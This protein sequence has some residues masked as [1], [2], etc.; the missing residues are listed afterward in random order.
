MHYI[1]SRQNRHY[2][3]WLRTAKAAGHARS[4][5]VLLEG[6]HLCSAWLQHYGAPHAV[7]FDE[8]QM[9]Q[10]ALKTF[11]SQLP[12]TDIYILE[13]GL[14]KQL[15]DVVSPQ[16]VIF[17]VPRPQLH[18]PSSITQTCVILDQ[19]QDPG[20]LGTILRTVA[21][22][23]IPHVFLT[24]GTTSAWSPKVLRS[25]QGAHFLTKIHEQMVL[26]ENFPPLDIPLAV[27]VLHSR[28]RSLYACDLQG[29]MAWAFGNESKGIGTP[30]QEA[31]THHV[32]IPHA[33]HIESLNVAV[34]AAVCLFE[35]QR[36]RAPHTTQGG[37]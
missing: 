33:P 5:M 29:P 20:N 30:W 34:A 16:G 9:Q 27:T 12:R 22:L 32:M 8:R 37:V 26:G 24:R 19:I 6:I 21:A 23:A 2:K 25:A 11:A 10:A 31:A 35:H 13:Q 4:E 28:A 36:Q 17:V 15:S 1:S 3:E 18:P 7:L 14:F